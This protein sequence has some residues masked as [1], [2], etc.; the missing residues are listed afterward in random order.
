MYFD[1]QHWLWIRQEDSPLPPQQVQEVCRAQRQ[2]ARSSND[3][4]QVT[5]PY[6]PLLVFRTT[7]LFC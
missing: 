7:V 5:I 4:Q 1:A 2:G 6:K 3:A